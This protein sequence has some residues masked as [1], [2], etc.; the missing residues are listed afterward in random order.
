M[1]TTYVENVHIIADMIQQQKV[2]ARKNSCKNK[3]SQK[4][5]RQGWYF[6]GGVISHQTIF[7]K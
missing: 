6:M 1:L 4:K 3:Q 5:Q 7:P 2:N